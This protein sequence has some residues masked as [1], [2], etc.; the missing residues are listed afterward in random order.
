MDREAWDS[1]QG[2]K[3]LTMTEVTA[4]TPLPAQLF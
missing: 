1:P 2:L 4:H 3:E